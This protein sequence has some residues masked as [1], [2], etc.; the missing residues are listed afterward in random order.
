MPSIVIGTAG[1]IDHGKSS[2]VQALTGKNPDRLPEEKRRGITIDL[3]FADLEL[4]DLRIGF[5]DVPGHERFVKN[6]LAGAHGI[7]AVALVIAADEGVMPQTREHFDICR[8]LGVVHGLI[9][10]TKTDLVE[11]EMLSLV[12]AEAAELVAGSFLEGAPM[13]AVSAKTAAGLE[14]LR[15]TLRQV[16]AETPARSADFV[17]RLPIDRVF[18]MKGFGAVVTGTLVSGQISEGD[19]LELLPAGA[20]VRVRGVQVHGAAVRS[21]AAGQRTAVNLASV[22]LSAIERGM[23]LAEVTRLA[24]TQILDVQLKV[25]ESAPRALRTRARVR[26]HI[27]SA[28][29]LGRVRVLNLPGEIAPGESAFAQLRL[30]TPVVALHGERFIIRSY[31]PAITIAG[32]VVLDPL[33]AKHRGR[34]LAKT[35]ERLHELMR[36]ERARKLAAFVLAAGDQGMT[37]EQLI[38]RM[39]LKDTVLSAAAT[40]AERAGTITNANGV[41]ISTANFEK[42]ADAVVAEMKSHHKRDPLSRGLA[43]EVLRERFFSHSAPEVFRAVMNRLESKGAVVTEK[44]LVRLSEHTVDLSTADTTLRDKIAAIYQ[45]AQ[46]EPP[47][48]D[49]ALETAGVTPAQRT[50]ARKLLQMLLDSGTLVRVHA[51][52][53][54][55]VSASDRLRA[56]LQDFA[57]QHEPERLLDVPQFKTL[58]SVSRKYAI[59]L[60]EYLDSE[61]ITRRAGDKRII[62]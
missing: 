34:E 2:L 54:L 56:L 12:R 31:S 19:E 3:G 28:E 45:A 15:A 39:G 1:H 62:L 6:M 29:V 17:T 40:E 21:A 7:D 24:T 5:V 50:H 10:I 57:S 13:I 36:P 35:D 4:G 27:G 58:A 16:A 37:L 55:H 43:R 9:V 42:F 51:E 59:P 49:R 60:L 22:E 44:D 30:E 47:T 38:A 8:L 48:L 32:G 33:A 26:V 61:R 52:M 23:V 53:F 25:L 14:E 46:L 11:E 18:T 41:F 20:R